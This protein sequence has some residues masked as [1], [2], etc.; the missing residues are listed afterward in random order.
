LQFQILILVY[1]LLPHGN[2]STENLP[3]KAGDSFAD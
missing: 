3:E 2:D 1:Y